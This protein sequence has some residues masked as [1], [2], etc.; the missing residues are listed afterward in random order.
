MPKQAKGI[1]HHLWVPKTNKTFLAFNQPNDN[2]LTLS[3]NRGIVVTTLLNRRLFRSFHTTQVQRS[4]ISCKNEHLALPPPV[5]CVNCTKWLEILWEST[6]TNPIHSRTY[7][8]NEAKVEQDKKRCWAVSIWPQPETQEVA[9]VGITPWCSKSASARFTEVVKRVS[10]RQGI[11][12]F[13]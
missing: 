12:Q 9:S 7:C 4:H 1:D 13:N 8:H 3:S 5:I 11:V 6:P 10:F 2:N